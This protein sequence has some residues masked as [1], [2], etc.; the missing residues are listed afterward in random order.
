MTETAHLDLESRSTCDLKSAGLYR[1]WE[2]PETEVL[3]VRWRIGDG[4]VGEW[5]PRD[6]APSQCAWSLLTFL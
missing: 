3:V 2:D 6:T 1:Y 4:P 5:R